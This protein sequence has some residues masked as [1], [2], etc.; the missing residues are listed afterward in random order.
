VSINTLPR[1]VI[2][3][4]LQGLRLPL[5]AV[6]RITNADGSA[7][8]PAVA[9][10]SFEAEAKQVLGALI[11]DDELVREGRLQRAKLGQLAEAERLEAAA[12]QK[13][14]AA[15]AR[16]ME[17]QA[18]AEQA[19]ARAEQQASRREEQIARDKAA[20]DREVLDEARRRERDAQRATQARDKVVTARERDAA[21]TRIREESAALSKRNE[22]LAATRQAHNLDEALSSKKAERKKS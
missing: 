22:A 15:D 13:R 10:E 17:R 12:D 20:R 16:L 9:Y 21:R 7:W 4:Y 2:K 11:R 8:P 18:S 5:T 6:E 3:A 19:R 14:Q 1:T